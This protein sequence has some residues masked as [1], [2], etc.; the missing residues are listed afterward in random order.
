MN[1]QQVKLYQKKTGM[2]S[3]KN[4]DLSEI[5]AIIAKGCPRCHSLE[6]EYGCRENQ[7]ECFKC[8]FHW[9]K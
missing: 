4:Q 2:D 3:N 1:P 7:F 6:V 8:G 5:L 9:G